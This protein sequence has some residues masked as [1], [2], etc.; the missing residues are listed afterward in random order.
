MHLRG[1]PLTDSFFYD[2]SLAPRPFDSLATAGADGKA[3][4][5][6]GVTNAGQRLAGS[7]L[8]KGRTNR[9]EPVRSRCQWD[10]NPRPLEVL[11]E[12]FLSC[13]KNNLFCAA[14][15]FSPIFSPSVH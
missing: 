5:N 12:Q 9:L 10:S 13:D 11:H 1:V 2:S 7:V 4:R 6:G 8:A 14:L 15:Y 3:R